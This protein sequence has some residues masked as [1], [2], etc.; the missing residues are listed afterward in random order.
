VLSDLQN[1]AIAQRISGRILKLYSEGLVPQ[2]EETL[3]SATAAY[4]V[5]KVDFQTLLSAVIDLLRLRQEYYRTMADHEIAVAK[6][7]EIIG[8]QP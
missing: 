8:D 1:Q 3:T 7:H 6:I 5:G 4:R 2:A